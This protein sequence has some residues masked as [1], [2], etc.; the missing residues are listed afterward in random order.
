MIMSINIDKVFS[1]LIILLATMNNVFADE[2]VYIDDFNQAIDLYTSKK[3]SD[4]EQIFSRLPGYQARI[5]YALS[6]HAQE[7]LVQSKFIFL[8]S[9]ILTDTDHQRFI[10]LYNAASCAFI[11]G[12]YAEAE[13]LYSDALHY[14][15]D[16]DAKKYM[17]LS[18][19]LNKLV[20]NELDK[21]MLDQDNK[22]SGG[23]KLSVKL[24]EA[25]FDREAGISMEEAKDDIESRLEVLYKPE[26]NSEIIDQLLEKGIKAI[27]LK[28]SPNLKLSSSHT[29]GR[30]ST[31]LLNENDYTPLSVSDELWQ[32]LFELEYNIPS[33]LDKKEHIPGLRP[34]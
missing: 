19:Q 18:S 31:D 28:E 1:I 6:M 8:S 14:Q 33:A 27:S 26:S 7:K 9:F 3:F 2:N 22:R 29:R 13:N 15:A 4:A 20:L 30:I 16:K 11:I 12:Q 21:N 32:R 25:L 5:A 34:W 17:L 24:D 23:G 10:T